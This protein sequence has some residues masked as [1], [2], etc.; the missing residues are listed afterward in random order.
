MTG[1]GRLGGT[2]VHQRNL[3]LLLGAILL[4]SG[5]EAAAQDRSN[6]GRHKPQPVEPVTT[7][8]DTVPAPPPAPGWF[9]GMTGGAAAGSDLFSVDVVNGTPTPWVSDAPFVADQFNATL[10][11]AAE[12]SIFAGR[13]MGDRV[14]LRGDLCWS[15]MAVSAEAKTGQVGDVYRYD[16]F[17]VLTMALGAEFR[18]VRTA[19]HPYLG[20]SLAAVQLSPGHATGLDQTNLGGRI[21]LGYQKVLDR[22]WSL[23][24]EGR[25]TR[26]GFSVGDWKPTAAQPN[27]PEITVEGESDLTIWSL[28]LGIQLELGGR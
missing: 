2:K 27:Q 21:S 5:A 28:V 3:G 15:D 17:G 4:L 22:Q 18:L 12:F 19:S 11:G 13:R 10:D 20:A 25:V 26:T 6:T 23:R 1:G 24:L 14:T 8:A 9:L 16:S 7:A